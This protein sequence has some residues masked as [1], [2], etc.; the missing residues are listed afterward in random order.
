SPARALVRLTDPNVTAQAKIV[1]ERG[2]TLHGYAEYSDG[3][4]ATQ[5]KLGLQPAWWHS[6]HRGA[7]HRVEPDGTFA[8]THIVSGTYDILMSVLDEDGLTAYVD[9][10]T[11]KELSVE[12]G[13]P[14]VVQLPMASPQA[15]AAI[16]GRLYFLGEG[17]PDDVFVSVR[18]GKKEIKELIVAMATMRTNYQGK[19][20]SVTGLEAGT[21]DL[22][23]SGGNARTMEVKGITAPI[24]NLEI[25]LEFATSP[26]LIGRVIDERTRQPVSD[27]QIRTKTVRGNSVMAADR[28]TRF[29]DPNGLF[30]L[31]MFRPGE[32]QVQV[33]ADGYAP[34]WSDPVDTDEEPNELEISLV[35]GGTLEG[36][37]VNQAGEPV[38]HA[39]ILPHSLA[40]D[41]SARRAHLFASEKGATFTQNGTFTLSHVPAGVEAIKVV[42]PDYTCLI[43]RDIVIASEQTTTLDDL[44]LT[45]GGAL[46]GIVLDEQM[47]PRAN[48][49]LCFCDAETG[50]QP[51]PSKR[52]ATTVTDANGFYY[53]A[54]LPARKCYVYRDGYQKATGVTRRTIIP[55][56]GETTRLDF[57]GSHRVTG[58]LTLEKGNPAKQ[59]VAIGSLFPM[60]FD[61]VSQTDDAGR[62]DF[63]GIIPGTYYLKHHDMSEGR[64]RWTRIAPVTVVDGDV[65]LGIVHGRTFSRKAMDQFVQTTQSSLELRPRFLTVQLPLLGP[66]LQ[67]TFNSRTDFLSGELLVRITHAD[68]V[69]E[70]VI[71]EDGVLS[72]GWEPMPFPQPGAGEIYFGFQSQQ[73]VLTASGDFLEIELRVVKDLDGIGNLQTGILRA[74]LY[75]TQ[76]TYALVMDEGQVP[77][78]F[79][80]MP[81]EVVDKIREGM[82][83]RAVTGDWQSYWPLEIT[84]EQGWLEGAQREQMKGLMEMTEKLK[85]RP[86]VSPGQ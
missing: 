11:R 68:Q 60:D 69:D 28:W 74:G 75:Q 43:Q 62:F 71:F 67:W 16:R 83:F 45:V 72:A 64:G 52:W 76:G 53:V 33:L 31:K 51:D 78:A 25:E 50:H 85:E 1:L 10:V 63:T 37:V 81:Q 70:Y 79:Q 86:A 15:G 2:E 58:T 42:H 59:R 5:I 22:H 34:C 57:G 65:D 32:Y 14:L 36:R 40:G 82:S 13:E 7:D 29:E 20:F 46:E 61:C 8:I 21:Y 26:H 44:V 6:P 41:T 77:E 38:D 73:K 47:L 35:P 27:F 4:P 49:T 54:H 3:K 55:V 56:D 24:E 17:R 80:S 30:N 66:L 23:I 9:T 19:R 18:S 39:K 48:E 12:D 84:S